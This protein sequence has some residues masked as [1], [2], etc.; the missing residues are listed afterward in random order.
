MQGTPLR[1]PRAA[2]RE[3]L[4][5]HEGVGVKGSLE[6]GRSPGGRHIQVLGRRAP[7]GHVVVAGQEH[8][9]RG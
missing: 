8:P 1:P 2:G 7:E 9:G 5:Q 3:L 6:S 4:L